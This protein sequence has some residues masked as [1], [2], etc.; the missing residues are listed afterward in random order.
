MEDR[1]LLETK[2][3]EEICACRVYDLADNIDT[4][5]DDDLR[6]IINHEAKCEVCGD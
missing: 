6:A 4:M 3:Q 2:A 5:T 1:E